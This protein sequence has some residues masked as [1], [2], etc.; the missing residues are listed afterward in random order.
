MNDSMID[1]GH[2]RALDALG[3]LSTWALA[4]IAMRFDPP[5]CGC[6][7]VANQFVRELLDKRRP[8]LAAWART[9]STSKDRRPT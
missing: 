4:A 7:L 5:P 9:E 1:L 3:E 8:S 2:C 6:G